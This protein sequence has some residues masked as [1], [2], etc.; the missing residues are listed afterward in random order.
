MKVYQYDGGLA[1][2]PMVEVPMVEVPMVEVPM[3]EA[4]HVLI[5]DFGGGS[6]HTE[7][8]DPEPAILEA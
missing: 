3:I 1:E 7:P 6:S 5:I 4:E 8:I 2:V